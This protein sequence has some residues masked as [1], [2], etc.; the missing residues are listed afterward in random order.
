MEEFIFVGRDHRQRAMNMP[1]LYKFVAELPARFNQERS[2][3]HCRIADFEIEKLCRRGLFAELLQ[4][5]LQRGSH[6]RLGQG[7]RCVVRSA[8]PAFVGWLEQYGAFRHDTR[9]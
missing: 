6:D 2:A 7:P 5:R 9:R 3:T 8:S 1:S 4:N